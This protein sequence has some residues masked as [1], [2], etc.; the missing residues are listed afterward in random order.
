[1]LKIGIIGCGAIADAHAWAIQRITGCEIIGACDVE[2]LMV[3]LF[4]ERF[5]V[6]H[7]FTNL[8]EMLLQTRPDVVHVL[9]P[10]QSHYSIARQ[11]LEHGC[12][13][14]IEKP[15]ALCTDEV[16]ELFRLSARKN[17]RVT[18]GHDAQFSPAARVLRRLVQDGYLGGAP[19]HMESYYGYEFGDLYGN[20]V[21]SDKLHW[22]R[23]LPGKLLQNVISHGIARIAEFLPGDQPQVMTHGFVSP[24]L[25]S[26]GEEEIIDELRVI[27][28]DETGATAYFTF[29]SQIRP[30]L[31]QFRIYGPKNGLFLNETQ[32]TLIKLR[33]G[34]F[35]SYAE[36]FLPPV[37]IAG[38]YLRNFARNLRLFWAH[39]FHMESGK[40][41]LT[42]SF[43]RSIID[44][45]PGPIPLRQ[46]W[47]TSRIMDQIFE[48]TAVAPVVKKPRSASPQ[49]R[50]PP[51]VG[52]STVSGKRIPSSN[53]AFLIITGDDWGRT[54]KETDRALS[55][56]LKGRLTS[57][58]AMVFMKDSERAAE[59]AKRHN[60]DVGL[61][62]NLVEHFT[63]KG[64]TEK[65]SRQHAS[66]VRF[67]RF[68]KYASILYNPFL[69]KQFHDDYCAQLEEFRRLYGTSPSHVN[70]H[71]HYHLCSNM[72]V[73]KII[74]P[75]TKVRRSFTFYAGQKGWLNLTYR[76]MV[77]KSLARRYVLTDSFFSLYYSLKTDRIA[78]IAELAK[79]TKVEL[80]VHPATDLEYDFLMG[81]GFDERFHGVKLATFWQL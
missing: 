77:N 65:H 81:N 70:G 59:L 28:S 68:N 32:Q 6:S 52:S 2:E 67:L 25:K 27:I 74:P 63:G 47:L 36:R 73:G 42:E 57:L 5:H 54:R 50:P 64:K 14:Y 66:I 7:A 10:P 8:G 18:V 24:P 34:R 60:V 78:H 37:S 61:H 75:G 19:V 76:K 4:C 40:K 55:C 79:S 13:L 35:K 38:Q 71:L 31:N 43:Y 30:S 48:Q 53:G 58:S 45:T 33:G 3:K 15:F 39:E 62:L 29:S 22:V 20:A 72:L 56:C 17:L 49:L 51:E 11:C 26:I 12:H 23:R 9:T 44:D 80:M 21:L 41:Y 16:E 69:R 1:M 46:I